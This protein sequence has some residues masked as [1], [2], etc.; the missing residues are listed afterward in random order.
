MTIRHSMETALLS[1]RN[2]A[3]A[4]NVKRVADQFKHSTDMASRYFR[5]TSP[6]SYD[7]DEE[8]TTGHAGAG[9]SANPPTTRRPGLR[10]RRA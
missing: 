3:S 9:T 7:D 4:A 2:G 5:L 1:V 6:A 8:T 10:P